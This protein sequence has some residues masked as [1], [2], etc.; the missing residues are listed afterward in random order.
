MVNIMGLTER[1]WF[2]NEEPKLTEQQLEDIVYE[3]KKAY[4]RG[5]SDRD[6]EIIRC[7]NCK[8]RPKE[9]DWKT[10][11]SGFDLEFPENSKCP[12]QCIEDG[13]YSW[14]PKDNWFCANGEW[15]NDNA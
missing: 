13:W 1:H 8:H 10:Y 11:V 12:C 15:R 4:E 3:N 9:P 2:E 7:K 5:Y 14:Y 6:K